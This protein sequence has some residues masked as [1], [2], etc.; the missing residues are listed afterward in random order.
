[1]KAHCAGRTDLAAIASLLA[2]VAAVAAVTTAALVA[3]QVREE[4]HL[5]RETAAL[6]SLW[7]VSEQWNSPAMLDVRSNAAAALRARKPSA[8]VA[9]I[10]DFFDEIVILVHR[11]ALDEGLTALHFYWPLANYWAATNEYIKQAQS[12]EPSAW[13]DIGTLVKRLGALEA[14]RRRRPISEVQP[15]PEEV[16]QFL[17]DEQGQDEC[18]D[19]S[20]AE[21]TPA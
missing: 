19:D 20:D 9:S 3:W 18:T 2:A 14:E 16:Q 21:K 15:T 6:D 12:E 11:G 1:M 10:L 7:H 4:T 8:D 13:N 5:A 17:A